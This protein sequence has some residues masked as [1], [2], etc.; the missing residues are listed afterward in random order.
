MIKDYKII[1]LCTTKLNEETKCSFAECLSK[2]AIAKGYRLFVFN[3]FRDFY[4]KDEYDLGASSVYKAINFA[5]LDALVIDVRAF[6]DQTIVDGVIKKA[7]EKNIPV[8][9]LN[10][11]REGCF[12]ITK[13]YRNTY[14]SLI[15]HIVEH[16]GAKNIDFIA[17]SKGEND[18]ETR[19]ACYKEVLEEEGIPFEKDRVFYGDYWNVPVYNAVDEI[20]ARGKPLPDAIICVNDSSA[21]DVCDRLAHYGY[22]VPEDIIVTGFDGIQSAS[23]YTPQLTTC[24]EDISGLARNCMTIIDKSVTEKCEP[25]SIIEEYR[26]LFSE[27]C[28]CHLSEDRSFRDQ[29]AHLFKQLTSASQHENMLYSWADRV[30][31]STDIGMVGKCLYENVLPGSI[32]CINGN[33]LSSAR[34]GEK[35]DP[36]APFSQ[37]MIVISGKDESYKNQSQDIFPLSDLYPKIDEV[38]SEEVMFVFQ[39]IYVADKVCGYYA[40]KTAALVEEAGKIHRLTRIINIAFGTLVSHIEQDHMISRIQDMQNRDPLTEQLNLKGLINRMKE[41]DH[42]ARKK[43]IA[44]SVYCITR[45]KYIYDTYGIQDAEEALNLISESLQLANPSNSIIARIAD[46]EFAVINLESPD[47]DMGAV[48]NAATSIFFSNTENYNQAQIKDYFVE[49]NCG[50]TVAEPGW[51]SD[52]QSLL[53]IAESEMYLNRLKNGG[54]GPIL[55]EHKSSK[56]SYIL[57]DLLIKKNLFI[58]NFQ[59]IIDARTGEI[60]AYEALMRTTSEI[61]MNPG[62]ILK[63]AEDY[64]RLYDIERATFENVL[65]FINKN[66]SKFVGKRVFINTIPG[67]FLNEK[68]YERIN[69]RYGQLLSDCVIEI[70]EQND[71]SDEELN[72]IKNFDG[73]GSGCQLAVDDYGAGYSNIVNLLRYKPDVIKIDRYLISDIHNDINKQMFVK[74]TIDFAQMNGI[75]TVAEGV[76]TI[77]ELKAVISYGVDLI[78]GFYT[79]RPSPDPLDTL[80]D[81]IKYEIVSAGAA[82]LASAFN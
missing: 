73:K 7:Q 63:I 26:A 4:H 58:Y 50:C 25:F 31:E 3:S 12:C 39:S 51:N 27:S 43:R 77:E 64:N 59:P 54:D 8:V 38:I 52:I 67:H 69:Y 18:S 57:F 15:R 61:G 13:D 5:V 62:E 75:K 24:S 48:I 65:E 37:K 70:T 71:L 78:Q 2:E 53:K 28:G 74:S 22:R 40:K 41:I 34:R 56:E 20:V 21:I 49:V 80:P 45:Y 60:Y 16:H 68:D 82:A 81:K 1:G 79:A 66:Y 55:K 29:A 30:F 35:T 6:Y 23:F 10:E 76:E 46:D 9:A 19:L 32:L 14:K 44:V 33:F 72:R 47:V 36:E 42:F 11:Y 17:G